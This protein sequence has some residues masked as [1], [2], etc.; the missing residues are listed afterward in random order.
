MCFNDQSDRSVWYLFPHDDF[1]RWALVNTNIGNT[2][3]WENATDWDNVEGVYSWPS[4][5]KGIL[6]WLSD[7]ALT[8]DPSGPVREAALSG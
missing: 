7:Y 2:K 5:G 8:N 3:G 4:P 1:L 6:S